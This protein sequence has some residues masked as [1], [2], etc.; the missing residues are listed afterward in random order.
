MRC[1]FIRRFGIPLT[2]IETGSPLQLDEKVSFMSP[3]TQ[4]ALYATGCAVLYL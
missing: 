1:A 3:S 4:P 2:S